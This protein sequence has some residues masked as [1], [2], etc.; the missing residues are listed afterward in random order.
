[1]IE[2]DVRAAAV[3]RQ[4]LAPPVLGINDDLLFGLG[5]RTSA[6]TAKRVANVGIASRASARGAIARLASKLLDAREPV[7]L[8]E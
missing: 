6:V 2:I 4:I 3:R 1:M 5:F 8:S 7:D